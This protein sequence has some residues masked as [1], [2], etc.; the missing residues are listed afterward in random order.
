MLAAR[1]TLRSFCHASFLLTPPALSPFTGDRGCGA[2]A[3][4]DAFSRS[5]KGQFRAGPALWKWLRKPMTRGVRRPLVQ[6]AQLAQFPWI[7]WGSWMEPAAA[8]PGLQR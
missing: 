3:V 4:N 2:R 5:V 6:T 8:R 7:A 1:H